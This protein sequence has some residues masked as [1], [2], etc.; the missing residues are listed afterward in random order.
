VTLRLATNRGDA[1]AAGRIKDWAVA[2][3]GSGDEAWIVTEARCV[4]PGRPP[5]QT[6]LVLLHPAASLSFRIAKPMLEISA[7]DIGDLG[8]AA[9]LLAAEGCC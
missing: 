2:R 3:F 7:A 8:E 5:R 9:A 6:T 4:E 1:A